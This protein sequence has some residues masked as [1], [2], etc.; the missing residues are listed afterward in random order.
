MTT[1]DL[2]IQRENIARLDLIKIDTEG[3]E[4]NVLLGTEKT[5]LRFHPKLFIELDDDMLR[6][7]Q[8]SASELLNWLIQR[9][10]KIFDAE[11]NSPVSAKQSFVH[12]HFDIICEE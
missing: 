8:S 6:R 7:Q 3:F 4:M 5:I 10:Y 11:T 1:L 2:F 9:E 12:C